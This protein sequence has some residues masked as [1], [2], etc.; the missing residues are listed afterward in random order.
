MLTKKQG[1]LNTL[2]TS[3]VSIEYRAYDK[4]SARYKNMGPFH[5]K[6]GVIVC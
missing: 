6:S 5:I 4:N 3:I 1:K 2:I